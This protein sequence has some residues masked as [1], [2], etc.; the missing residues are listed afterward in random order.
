[1]RSFY[2]LFYLRVLIN[3]A[4]VFFVLFY[5]INVFPFDKSNII[6][7]YNSLINGVLNKFAIGQYNDSILFVKYDENKNILSLKTIGNNLEVINCFSFSYL[8]SLYSCFLVQSTFRNINNWDVLLVILDYEGEVLK[9]V[10]VSTDFVDTPLNA[11]FLNNTFVIAYACANNIKSPAYKLGITI[12]DSDL[13]VKKNYI[14]SLNSNE[15]LSRFYFSNWGVSSLDFIIYAFSY[16]KRNYIPYAG[17]IK[18][19]N[20][21][22]DTNLK[23][24]NN[25]PFFKS[26]QYAIKPYTIK[27]IPNL[28]KVLP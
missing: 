8:Y 14:L 21:S 18:L 11:T 7:T 20:Y 17:K 16:D 5:K 23:L 26:Y 10:I 3:F 28:E 6:Y 2:R 15:V 25:Y 12:L 27:S 22:I 9:S 13:N 1:M 24:E 4:L 19:D